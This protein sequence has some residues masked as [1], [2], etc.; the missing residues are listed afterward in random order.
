MLALVLGHEGRRHLP[1]APA[2][3]AREALLG[4]V[5]GACRCRAGR[6]GRGRRGTP[7][8]G[9]R[10]GRAAGRRGRCASDPSGPRRFRAHPAR[11]LRILAAYRPRWCR[12][13]E[14]A[15]LGRWS[16]ERAGGRC[17]ASTSAA[18]RS[19][20]RWAVRT[21]DPR[22]ERRRPTEPSG[23]PA[24]RRRRAWSRTPGRCS[25]RQGVAAGGPRG[26]RRLGAG[27]L[28]PRDAATVL[29]PPNLPGWDDVPLRDWLAD[30]LGVPV[31]LDNDAN[32]AAL[33]EW[34]F[35]AG[36]G[37]RHLVY[38]TMST[39]VGAGLILD[40]RALPRRARGRGR[41]RPRAARVGR[42]ARAAAACAA[43]PRRTSAARR[44][45]RRLR[46]HHAGGEPRRARSPGGRERVTPRAPRRGGARGRRLRARRARALRPLPRR[47]SSRSPSSRSR[48]RSS[49]SARSPTAAGEALCFEPRAPPGRRRRPGRSLARGPPHPPRRA[50][51]RASPPTPASPSPGMRRT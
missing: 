47:G 22:R 21:V 10:S 1:V 18:P 44:S 33:A 9:R 17:S 42:R 36:R 24:R 31:Q 32:A 13:L 34:R 49:C 23:D 30:A 28:R 43:A 4:L 5:E 41:A 39:G 8:E 26:G 29:R 12:R 50:R 16:P 11:E 27:A 38:L 51:R 40:G 25:P 15:I 46:A 2:H 7:T 3:E 48:P 14:G 6:T 19:P 37:A 20:T 35:G 45:T